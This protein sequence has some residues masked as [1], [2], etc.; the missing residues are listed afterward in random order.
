MIENSC[1]VCGP[2]VHFKMLYAENFDLKY[3]DSELFSARKKPKGLHYRMAQCRQCGL[4]FSNPILDPS[5]LE[6]LYEQSSFSY[7]EDLENAKESY[8]KILKKVCRRLNQ[9]EAF[10]EVGCSNGFLL[11]S[12]R[13]LGF[14]DIRGIEPN[15][16]AVKHAHESVRNFIHAGIL[17]EGLYPEKKF[18]L[19]CAFHLFDHL[20]DPNEFLTLCHRYLKEDGCLLFV[21]HNA[22]ALPA[23]FLKDRCPIIDIVHPYLYDKS[24]QRK[25]FM[26]NHFHKIEFFNVYDC[27]SLSYWVKLFPLSEQWKES[28]LQFLRAL[29]IERFKIKFPVGNM[30]VVAQK[31]VNQDISKN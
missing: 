1:A 5:V 22:R 29:K 24:T 2:G 19:I 13:E 4:V 30:G 27:Y 9:R 8:K 25:I 12:A 16:E 18:D 28:F 26:K 11:E 10:L 7:E 14:K 15:K 31:C 21:H 6:N 23:K 3:V 20:T 17:K